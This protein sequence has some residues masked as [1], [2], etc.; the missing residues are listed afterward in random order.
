MGYQRIVSQCSDSSINIALKEGF[1]EH[2]TLDTY[3]IDIKMTSALSPKKPQTKFG[4]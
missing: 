4:S 1:T 2:G 3:L